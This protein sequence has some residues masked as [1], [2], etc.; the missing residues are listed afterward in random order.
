MSFKDALNQLTPK[1]RIFV[2]RVAEGSSYMAA[3]RAAG[4]GSPS[5]EASK[6]SKHPKVV[7]ALE[8]LNADVSERMITSK[9]EVERMMLEAYHN[10]E[11]A[12]EQVMAAREIGKLHGHYA[13]TK[14]ETQH[15]HTGTITHQADARKMS[16]ADLL[17]IADDKRQLTRDEPEPI[18]GE[19]EVVK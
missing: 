17:K 5:S 7:A 15:T 4:Y 6:V 16:H 10:A 19:F 11:T 13:P 1:Q 9:L 18:E 3:A 8:A 12:G 14:T 2:E